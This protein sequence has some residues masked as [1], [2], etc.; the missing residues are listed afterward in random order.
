ML[1]LHDSSSSRH[2]LSLSST[3]TL[4]HSSLSCALRFIMVLRGP[5]GSVWRLDLLLTPPLF[6]IYLIHVPPLPIKTDEP[7]V[8]RG[9]DTDVRLDSKAEGRHGKPKAL[10]AIAKLIGSLRAGVAEDAAGDEASGATKLKLRGAV[11]DD[12]AAGEVAE[13]TSRFQDLKGGVLADDAEIGE[14]ELMFLYF[15]YVGDRRLYSSYHYLTSFDCSVDHSLGKDTEKMIVGGI[16]EAT[17]VF[18]AKY[19]RGK[20]LPSMP[21]LYLLLR[22]SAFV[23]HSPLGTSTFSTRSICPHLGEE[24]FISDERRLW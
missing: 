5:L 12:G 6:C 24:Y 16:S 13:K 15:T 3:L 10:G 9:G 2:L 22:L 20:H 11:V 23:P 1:G 14:G 8:P 4:V 18:L 17:A 21:Y 19:E 7:L